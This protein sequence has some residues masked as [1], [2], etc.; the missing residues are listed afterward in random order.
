MLIIDSKLR[1]WILITAVRGDKKLLM[2]SLFRLEIESQKQRKRQNYILERYPGTK[3]QQVVFGRFKLAFDMP[4]CWLFPELCQ[5]HAYA[6]PRV[7]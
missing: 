5:E 2:E 1:Y 7:Y 3:P 6:C 4:L